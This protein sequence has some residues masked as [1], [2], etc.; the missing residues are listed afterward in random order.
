VDKALCQQDLDILVRNLDASIS[1]MTVFTS[2]HS[3][4]L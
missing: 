4:G 1:F 3:L 2:F